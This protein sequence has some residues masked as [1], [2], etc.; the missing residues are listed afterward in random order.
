MRGLDARLLI[1]QHRIRWAIGLDADYELMMACELARQQ[2]LSDAVDDIDAPPAMF[3]Y[4]PLLLRA[5]NDGKNEY[6]DMLEMKACTG[7][8]DSHGDPCPHHG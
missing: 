8:F 3:R 7:C 1:A 4:E 2:G 6:A 5:W